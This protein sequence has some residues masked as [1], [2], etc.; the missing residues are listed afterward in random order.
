MP[1]WLG[2]LIAAALLGAVELLTLTL[3]LGVLAVG[4]LVAALV[5][6]VGTPPLVQ[7]AS[8]AVVSL[9]GLIVVRPAVRRHMGRR[10]PLR[11]GVRALVGAQA[12]VVQQVT[13]ESGR[14]RIG[15]EEWSARAFDADRVIGVGTL[16]DV[17]EID[18]ATAV[19]HP[20]E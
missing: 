4:A 14:V 20:R 17:F 16:V 1:W 6:F 8:F 5:A 15:G 11:T 2:W 10:P 19:V 13:A 9:T 18:G 3:A 7:V 12:R